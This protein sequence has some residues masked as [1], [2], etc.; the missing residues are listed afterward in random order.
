MYYEET[1]TCEGFEGIYFKINKIKPTKL[2]AYQTL[3]AQVFGENNKSND[4]IQLEKCCDFILE[5]MMFSREKEGN[6][7][8]VQFP[9]LLNTNMPE[10]ERNPNLVSQLVALFLSKV[11]NPVQKN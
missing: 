4:E 11:T 9:G 2:F 7:E 5:N 1:F 8:F 3:L 6:Y 10:I